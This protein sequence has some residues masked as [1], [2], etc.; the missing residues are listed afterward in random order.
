MAKSGENRGVGTPGA[1]TE[2]AAGSGLTLVLP[3]FNEQP[4]IDDVLEQ[5]L[6]VLPDLVE[7]FE[8][9]VVD[10]GST[11]GT[12]EAV[13]KQVD[14]HY[15]R[16]RLLRHRTNLGYGVALRSGFSHAR[17]DLMFYTDAD[18]QFDLSELA[19][20]L[21]MAESNDLVIGFRVYRYDTVLR[22]ILS[23][24][25]NRMVGV[26]FRVKVRDVDCAYKLMTREVWEKITLESDDFFVD[27]EIVAR[28][29]KWNFR[30]AQK[31]VRHYPRVA[32][33]TT[34]APSDIP[35]TLR[36]T[37]R[38]WR[39]IYMPTRDQRR[40]AADANTVAVADELRPSA[41]SPR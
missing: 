5:A 13:M 6:T 32:G 3:A 31:G 12:S 39:R 7:N 41:A 24:I 25:Y 38:M 23:W 37:A 40:E 17:Y 10:D 28:A 11:D 20:F 8:V 22:S 26:L 9:I 2:P 14:R 21:P 29:R 36:V 1:T 33:E 18:R 4:N 27:A 30:I 15:P 19:F 34:V 16:V 35:N